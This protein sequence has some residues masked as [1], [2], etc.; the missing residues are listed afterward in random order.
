LRLALTDLLGGR[1]KLLALDEP[2]AKLDQNNK[3]ALVEALDAVKKRLRAKGVQLLVVSH[4]LD[5][6][7][8][9]DK[10]IKIGG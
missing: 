8:V 9:A 10:E 4:D 3:S 7:R 5:V 2:A 1:L 6:L